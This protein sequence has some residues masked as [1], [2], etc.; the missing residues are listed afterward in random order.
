MG[1][2]GEAEV[3]EILLNAVITGSNR[4]HEHGYLEQK[5][6]T[7]VYSCL[8]FRHH[9]Q[10]LRPHHPS[11]RFFGKNVSK[12]EILPELVEEQPETLLHCFGSYGLVEGLWDL[13]LYT[14]AFK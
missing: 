5:R 1:S 9:L 10:S 12:A 4:R 11:Q 13:E 7:G 6:K 3:G 2:G 14:P 8:L